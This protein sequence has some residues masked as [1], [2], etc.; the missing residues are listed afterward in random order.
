MAGK[1]DG[2]GEGNILKLENQIAIIKYVLLFTNAIK[3]VS[4]VLSQ[5]L[6]ATKFVVSI[7]IFCSILEQ[8]KGNAN[9]FNFP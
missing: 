2:E 4:Y 3:W 5:A 1:G 6:C 9:F 8:N 7:P